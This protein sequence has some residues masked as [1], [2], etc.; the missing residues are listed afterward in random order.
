MIYI[1]KSNERKPRDAEHGDVLLIIDTGRWLYRDGHRWIAVGT[2]SSGSTILVQTQLAAGDPVRIEFPIVC[3]SK[4]A[5]VPQAW[6]LDDDTIGVGV[7]I[8][9]ID[10][11]GF[12]AQTDTD[13][14]LQ[15]T[16]GAPKL[17]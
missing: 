16:Y 5:V 2:G 13:C 1:R 7:R 3:N 11:T 10:L 9:L 17:I 15:F 6:A 14:T 8:S 12:T 4:P